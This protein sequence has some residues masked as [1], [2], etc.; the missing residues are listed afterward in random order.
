M[1][2]VRENV[3][4]WPLQ[5]AVR[6]TVTTPLIVPAVAVKPA[7]MAP[8]GITTATGVVTTELLLLSPIV[9]PPRGAAA[10]SETMH[11]LVPAEPI[12]PGEQF[13]LESPVAAGS[14]VRVAVSVELPELAVIV[15]LC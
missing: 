10:V 1:E 4:V 8:D 9:N 13:R 7:L 3:A 11:W 5:L 6:V 2:T 12:A 15:E 14:I